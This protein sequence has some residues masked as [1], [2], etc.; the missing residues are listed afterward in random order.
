MR[1]IYSI[2]AVGILVISSGCGSK[3]EP[4]GPGA[5]APHN[6][7]PVT[8]TPKHETFKISVPSTAT[9]LKQGEEKEVT[10]E[11]ERSSDFKQDVTLTLKGDKGV[12]VTPATAVVKASS[13]DTKVKAMVAAAADAPIGDATVHVLAKP[14]TGDSTSADFKVNVKGK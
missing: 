13:S 7:N 9:T 10:I 14:E 12:T 4:G 5:K 6:Q 2:L 3:S 8:G 1:N 11:V